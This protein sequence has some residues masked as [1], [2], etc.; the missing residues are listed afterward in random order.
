MSI[1]PTSARTFSDLV[2]AVAHKFGM[3]YY[4]ADGAGLTQIPVDSHDLALC[5]GIVNS[6]IRMFFMNAPPG[7]WRFSRPTSSVFLWPTKTGFTVSGGVY[8]LTNNQTLLTASSAILRESME[9]KSIVI[10]GVGAGTYTIKQYVS[11][12]TAYV[13]GNASTV[14]NSPGTITTDGSY[15]LPRTFAGTHSGGLTFASGTNQGS[16]MQWVHPASIRQSRENE[17]DTSG[18]PLLAAI[19]VFSAASASGRARRYRMDVYPT[20]SREFEVQFQYD[21]NFDVLVALTEYPPVPI[22]HDETVKAACLAVGE[23]EIEDRVDGP[24]YSYYQGTCL[25]ASYGIDAR[26][27]PRRLGYFGN[28]QIGRPTSPRGW[29]PRI[30]VQFNS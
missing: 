22:V 7:G 10:T 24:Y 14:S 20:P 1:E 25:P 27:G 21:L 17:T 28:P 4:G 3:A 11:T 2:L 29:L 16:T 19:D 23:R 13:T 8:D 5:K 15:T 18:T 12:T 6:G 26:T 9:E 30:D